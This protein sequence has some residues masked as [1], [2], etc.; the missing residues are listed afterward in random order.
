MTATDTDTGAA[1][2]RGILESPGCDT[3][4]LVY[5]DWLDE[6]G[7]ARVPCPESEGRG[8]IRGAGLFP[9][10]KPCLNCGGVAL[11][12]RSH[13]KGAGTVLSTGNRDRAEFIRVQCWLEANPSCSSCTGEEWLH[14]KPCAECDQRELFRARRNDL[15]AGDYG[16][17]W[18]HWVGPAIAVVPAGALYYH[19]LEFSRGFVAAV[20]C[21]ADDWLAHGDA[22]RERHPVERVALTTPFAID[23]IG[24]DIVFVGDPAGTR[25]PGTVI[26]A[27][28]QPD[29]LGNILLRYRFGPGIK[30]TF[31]APA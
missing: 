3:A 12:P 28:Y 17:N 29:T 13:R 22:I 24:T 14:G 7:D 18:R 9:S 10:G 26:D 2:M 1:L 11:S 5:A 15:L 21:S 25:I 19:H 4:R 30:F 27:V 8:E 6:Q 23:Q 20:T 16:R 31:P